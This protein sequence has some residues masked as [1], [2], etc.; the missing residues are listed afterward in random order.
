MTSICENR[1]KYFVCWDQ[2]KTDTLKMCGS[3]KESVLP[4]LYISTVTSLCGEDN[5][6]YTIG[7]Y[8]KFTS[9]H[10]GNQISCMITYNFNWKFLILL[11]NK[12]SL[13]KASAEIS[14]DTGSPKCPEE[15]GIHWIENCED[16]LPFMYSDD[17]CA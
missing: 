12:E 17:L 3:D 2:M 14:Q 9:N 11:M 16:I 5:G 10:T 8:I 7:N 13:K 4:A 6:K 1:D 15:T